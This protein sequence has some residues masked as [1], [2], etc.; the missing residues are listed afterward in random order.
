MSAA[1]YFSNIIENIIF[2]L[3]TLSHIEELEIQDT[4]AVDTSN[5][6]VKDW[7]KLYI[8]FV[9]AYEKND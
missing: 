9:N 5:L 7:Y 3:L 2:K 6:F 1:S 4:Y 8:C